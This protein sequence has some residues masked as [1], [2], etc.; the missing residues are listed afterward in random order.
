MEA[1]L[2]TRAHELGRMRGIPEAVVDEVLRHL[3]PSIQLC[4]FI[5]DNEV[6][7]AAMAGGLPRL[8]EGMEWPDSDHPHLATID[9]AALPRDV[10]DIDL[11]QDGH[12]LVFSDFD[13]FDAPVLLYIPAGTE[14]TER[15]PRV[16]DEDWPIHAPE[17]LY[18]VVA[19]YL[20]NADW[21]DIPGAVEFAE[22]IPSGERNMNEFIED[23]RRF[24]D[25]SAGFT[26]IRLGGH[27]RYF[28]NPPEDDGLTHFLTVFADPFDQAL[29]LAFAGTREDIAARRYEKLGCYWEAV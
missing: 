6:R 7:P 14:T 18:P 13:R 9:Y 17:P 20:D 28:Q 12:L 8:P 19:R 11:P 16:V 15:E 25:D 10:L 5:D 2:R 27:S 29:D 1:N 26:R 4:P 22:H 3:R 24:T 23:L 21:S